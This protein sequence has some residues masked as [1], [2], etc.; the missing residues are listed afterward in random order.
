MGGRGAAGFTD[1]DAHA[2]EGQL[3]P[4]LHR[5]AEHRH[6]A[7]QREA[8]GDHGAERATVGDARDR[9]AHHGVHD[10]ESEPVDDTD[11]GVGQFKIVLD[12]LGQHRRQEPV[13]IV[14]GADQ[15]EHADSG[16]RP[17][18]AVAVRVIGVDRRLWC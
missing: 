14:Q 13:D 11:C 16:P 2:G 8:P 12:R 10:E 17:P 3:E 18:R 1:R 7:P 5:A 4:R 9:D 6:G 15:R